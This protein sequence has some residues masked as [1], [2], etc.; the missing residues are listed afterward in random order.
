MTD[1]QLRWT[2]SRSGASKSRT[3]GGDKTWPSSIGMNLDKLREELNE[4]AIMDYI[5][6]RQCLYQHI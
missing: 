1:S 3:D 4:M 6:N 5:K 2:A